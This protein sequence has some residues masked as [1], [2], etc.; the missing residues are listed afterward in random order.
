MQI[1]SSV[2]FSVCD[3]G[4]LIIEFEDKEGAVFAPAFLPKEAVPLAIDGILGRYEELDEQP[5]AECAGH[6]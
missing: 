3:H 4:Q 6:A 5:L 1:A 2:K